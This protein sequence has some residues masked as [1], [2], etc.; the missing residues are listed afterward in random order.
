MRFR[1]ST[2]SATLAV[3]AF[4]VCVAPVRAATVTRPT[5]PAG[6]TIVYQGAGDNK[7]D[8]FI[9]ESTE[10][11][12][13]FVRTGGDPITAG[14]GCVMTT[15]PDCPAPGTVALR[16]FLLGGDDLVG[17]LTNLPIHAEGGA[18]NDTITGG[19]AADTFLGE[20]GDDTLNGLSGADTL[21][22][23]EGAD[24][25]I[26]VAAN[27]VVD[28]GPGD[29]TIDTVATNAAGAD[30]AG[31]DDVDT[32]V[33]DASGART[34]A[35]DIS[36]DDVANDTVFAGSGLNVRADVENVTTSSG[37]DRLIGSAAA[38]RLDAG[39][40]ADSIV[41]GGGPDTLLGGAGDDTIDA[42]DGIVDTVDCGAGDDRAQV[43][44]TDVVNGCEVAF[45]DADRDGIVKGPDCN[46]ADAAIRPGAI[47]V[48]D[49][50]IDEDCSGAD[51]VILDRDGD[52]F[53]RPADCD[54]TNPAVHPGATEVP[55]NAVD[56]NCD[57]RAAPFPRITSGVVNVWR[58]SAKFTKVV[59]LTVR[60]APVG[61]V[62]RVRCRGRG[63]PAGVKR[64]RSKGGKELRFAGFFRG[65]RLRVGAV[66][67]VRITLAG[68]IG[69]VVRY[70][71]VAG[72]K[73]KADI[74]C[75]APGASKPRACPVGS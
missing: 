53:P 29:D 12:S 9:T 74:L 17:L 72:R 26:S 43:D 52:S 50:G 10:K 58:F 23:G 1:R 41:G 24:R 19:A 56:E 48:P 28:G 16:V 7:D 3:T 51:A 42:Q 65:R 2:V 54:D 38:N 32:L 49:N 20:A 64:Q 69:K 68:R 33:T 59:R 34:G 57:G 13:F 63:C 22:G 45:E 21:L 61:A 4:V 44:A 36:L 15:T 66:I 6:P 73:P 25:L 60:D 46:D 75:L 47:D 70:T 18:G 35:E 27:E 11:F 71:V 55:G 62:A 8:F 40:G 67:E 14:T 30:I 39:N 5:L 31:G 37:D